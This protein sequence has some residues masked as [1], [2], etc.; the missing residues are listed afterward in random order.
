MQTHPDYDEKFS[1]NPDPF[2]RDLAFEKIMKDVMLQRRKEELE[3]YKLHSQ[4][5]SFKASLYQSIK[6]ALRNST[7][8]G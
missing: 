3:L 7:L 2:S 5:T 4:D 1:D 8:P 6:E